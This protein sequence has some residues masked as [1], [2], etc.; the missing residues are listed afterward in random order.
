M[1]ITIK[2]TLLALSICV[3]G[4]SVLTSCYTVQGMGKDVS[5]LT[6][7]SSNQHHH[8]AHHKDKT[9]TQKSQ[10]VQKTKAPVK[11]VVEPVSAPATG[12]APAA[13]APTS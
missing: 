7:S 2:N 4:A 13:T 1:N 6:G 3:F 12:V 9:V 8:K 10:K 11:K 5:A